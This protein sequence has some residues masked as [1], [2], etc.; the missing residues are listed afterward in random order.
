MIR[1]TEKRNLNNLVRSI[2]NSKEELNVAFNPEKVRGKPKAIVIYGPPGAGKGTQANLTA[3]C[4]SFVH[5][6][7]GKY[8]ESLIYNPTYKKNAIIKRERNLFETGKLMTPSWVFDVVKTRAE[9]IAKAGLGIILSG[10]PRTLYETKNFLPILEKL[11]GRKNILFF[12]IKVAPSASIK[13]NSHRL[14]CIVCGF[15]ILYLKE[16]EHFNVKSKCP[17]CGGKLFRRSLDKLQIIKKRIEEYDTRTKPI[18]AELKKRGYRLFEIKGT[19]LPFGVFK[20]I[21]KHIYN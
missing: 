18:F 2:H 21:Q 4:F 8:L 19:A 16:T 14:L 10:S 7:T 20:N 11:Y 6:D 17:F 5:F 1:K 12:V 9:K 3:N 15:P 13:R